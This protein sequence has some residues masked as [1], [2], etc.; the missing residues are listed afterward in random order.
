[1]KNQFVNKIKKDFI[2]GILG[3]ALLGGGCAGVLS[4]KTSK[5]S[6]TYKQCIIE[7]EEMLG[8]K[9]II[10][11]II[12]DGGCIELLD[13][14]PRIL[15]EEDI[16]YKE[17]VK[18]KNNYKTILP[19]EI[20]PIVS[21]KSL[22]N[23]FNPWE[24]DYSKLT[25]E[26]A[27]EIVKTVQ[28]AEDYNN[29]HF[30]FDVGISK[31]N[32]FSENHKDRKGNCVDYATNVAAL[33]SNDGYPP[34]VL[35][36]RGEKDSDAVFLYRTKKGFA[37]KDTPLGLFGSSHN[38]LDDLIG[39]YNLY[40]GKNYDSYFIA[41]LDKTFP[42]KKWISG[43]KNFTPLLEN[44][45]DQKWIPFKKEEL[46]EEYKEKS[47][48]YNFYRNEKPKFPGRIITKKELK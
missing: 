47:Y 42:N 3:V 4:H 6:E 32:S 20:K 29:F 7:E 14:A 24:I 43:G 28:Q 27:I 15:N 17:R 23:L 33:L 5:N 45:A 9:Y 18:E 39:K 38:T 36:M 37:I 8:K 34:Y 40:K 10:P 2:A 30:S 31:N 44:L 1:M 16:N 35:F 22:D 13:T 25:P 41:D 12:V 26:Q 21:E 46:T 19:N 48:V 11:G